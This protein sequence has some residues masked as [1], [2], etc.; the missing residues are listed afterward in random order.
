MI[1][2]KTLSDKK[3]QEE[4]KVIEESF[5]NSD[6]VDS[7]TKSMVKE[8]TPKFKDLILEMVLSD[9]YK[10][11][12]KIHKFRRGLL[13]KGTYKRKSSMNFPVIKL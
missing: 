4:A 1:F 6:A 3:L 2:D 10:D 11:S 7:S 13:K 9:V 12:V 5:I 8:F